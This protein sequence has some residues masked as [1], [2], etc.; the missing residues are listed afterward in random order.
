MWYKGVQKLL[1]NKTLLIFIVVLVIILV[2]YFQG[3]KAGLEKALRY[4]ADLPNSGSGIPEN[5]DPTSLA[6]EGFDAM[7]GMFSRG[8]V[9]HAWYTKLMALTDDQFTA[10]Y[11][12]FNQLYINEGYGTMHDWIA[13]ESFMEQPIEGSQEPV[14]AR[15]KALNLPKADRSELSVWKS[16]IF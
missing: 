15:L 11:N 12:K 10:V 3:R 13:S 6:Q 5:W 4:G 2:I 1:L 8:S 7:T 16:L 9:L 14:L